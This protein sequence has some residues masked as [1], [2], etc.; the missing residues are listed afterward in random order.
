MVI[1][2]FLH[3]TTENVTAGVANLTLKYKGWKNNTFNLCDMM[4]VRKVYI[5]LLFLLPPNYLFS[6]LS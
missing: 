5:L 3:L 2:E 4:N 6:A 1:H